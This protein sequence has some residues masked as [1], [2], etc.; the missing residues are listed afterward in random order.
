MGKTGKKEVVGKADAQRTR[1]LSFPTERPRIGTDGDPPGNPSLGDIM[2]AITFT[3]E[4]LETKI[5]SLAV[6]LDQLRKGQRRLAER[7]TAT[8]QTMGGLSPGLTAAEARITK[9]EKQTEVLVVRAKD[10]ENRSRRNNIRIRPPR[11]GWS[12]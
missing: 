7:V 12:V 5:N 6:D 11:A 10:V 3:R 2:Q 1:A 8:E 9:L 4:G